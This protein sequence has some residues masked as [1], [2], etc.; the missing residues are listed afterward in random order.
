VQDTATVEGP[1]RRRGSWSL[2]TI[3]ENVAGKPIDEFQDPPNSIRGGSP[4]HSLPSRTAVAAVP[5]SVSSPDEEEPY[6]PIAHVYPPLVGA[7]GRAYHGPENEHHAETLE[8]HKPEPQVSPGQPPR[9]PGPSHRPERLYLH[10]L[11]LHMDR[12]NDNALR[13]LQAAVEEEVVH[14]QRTNPPPLPSP[15]TVPPRA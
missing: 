11:L 13:Y 12:L 5:T 10:Y 6:D 1:A 9:S 14:R 15:G 2:K 8:R 7:H 3:V 4:P